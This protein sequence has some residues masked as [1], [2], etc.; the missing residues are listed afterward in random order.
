[1]R[2]G[3]DGGSAI[4]EFVFLAV[5]FLLP[6]TYLLAAVAL[7]QRNEVALAAAA[8]N[9]GRAFATTDQPNEVDERVRTAVRLALTDQGLPEDAVVRFVAADAPCTAPPVAPRL[10]PGTEFA[11]CATRSVAL[12][13]VPTVLAGRGIRV[14][15]RYVVHVDDFRTVG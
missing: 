6:L 14:V 9:A 3:A 12:P 5:T 10:E 1:V 8:R 4:V 2:R 11:V 13:G 7:V 15:G